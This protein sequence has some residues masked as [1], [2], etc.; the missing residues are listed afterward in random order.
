[1]MPYCRS[2]LPKVL[3]IVLLLILPGC[4]ETSSPQI[5]NRKPFPMI[6]V[7]GFQIPVFPTAE[8]QFNYTRSWFESP[9][10]KRASL[11]AITRIFTQAREQ[12]GEAAL[13]LSFLEL[14]QDY[15]LAT[16]TDCLKVITRY[17]QILQEFQELPTIC[18]KATWYIGWIYCD[19]LKEDGNGLDMYQTV[20]ADYPQVRLNLTPAVPWITFINPSPDT[21]GKSQ[22]N[23]N[24]Y[25]ADLAR[26]EIVRHG[27]DR[28]TVWKAFHELW[29]TGRNNQAI[30]IALKILLA[31]PDFFQET[32]PFATQYLGHENN[33]TLA[34]DI[35]LALVAGSADGK[36]AIPL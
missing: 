30:G 2:F 15:R 13:D 27:L 29:D 5:T 7:D 10:E 21:T 34:N 4:K 36:G 31:R 18:A 33:Q 22:N 3:A 24:P 19:L 20:V 28:K 17:R 23:A 9:E 16:A 8:E 1:M 26:I 32:V 14:G 35:R 12:Q 11:I 25:W 6:L